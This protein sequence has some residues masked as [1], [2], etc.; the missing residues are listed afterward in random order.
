MKNISVISFRLF[1][2]FIFI[3]PVTLYIIASIVSIFLLMYL[4][5]V[6]LC[7]G[8]DL[9]S[10]KTRLESEVLTYHKANED[11]KQ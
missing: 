3:N 11:H 4:A 9:N 6:S 5:D 1:I 2:R 8:E 10:L 7:D